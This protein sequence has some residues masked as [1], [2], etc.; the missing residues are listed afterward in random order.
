MRVL[1]IAAVVA[2]CA[3]AQR[4]SGELRLKVLDPSGLPLQ[5]V[6]TLYGPA[7]HVRVTFHTDANGTAAVRNVPFGTYRV[8]VAREGFATDSRT[9]EIQFAAPLQ[10][11]VALGVAPVNAAVVVEDVDPLIDP[12]RTGTNYFIGDADL[13]DRRAALPGRGV[14]SMIDEQPGW[15]LEANG[16]LHPRGAEYGVQYVIDGIPMT[17]NRSPSFSP[18]IE[19]EDVQAMNVMTSGYPAEF[20]RKLG[21]VIEVATTT[22][23]RDGAHG[24][25]S[26]LGQSFGTES[27]YARIQQGWK[28]SFVALSGDAARSDRYLDPPVEENF[29]NSGTTGGAGLRF[30]RDLTAGDRIRFSVQNRAVRFE[31]PNERI[32]QAAGQRQDRTSGEIGGT[33]AYTRVLSPAWVLD[34]RGTGRDESAR[35][36]SN[37]FSTP[38]LAGQDRGFREG[39]GNASLS[40]NPARNTFKAGVETSFTSISEAFHFDITAPGYFDPGI[41]AAFRFNQRAEGREQAAYIQDAIHGASWNISAGL[42]WDHYKLLVGEQAWSPRL[43]AAW[44]STRLGLIIRGSYDRAFQTPAFENILLASSPRALLLGNAAFAPIRPSRGDFIEGG[45][46]KSLFGR[47]RIDS[48]YFVRRM[49]NFPDDS[50]LLNTGVTF[51]ISFDHGTVRGTEVKIEVPR[52]GPVSGF[53]SYTNMLGRAWLPAAGGLFLGSDTALL[54]SREQIPITQ[55][56]RNTARAWLRSQLGRRAWAAAGASYGSGLPVD[57]ENL[58]IETAREQYGD[59]I[60][61][62]VN[63]QRGRLRPS[64]SL[65]FSAGI[66]VWRRDEYVLRIQGDVLNATERLNVINFAGLFSGTALAAPRTVSVRA[67][68]EF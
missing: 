53:V 18:E 43:G 21:G 29:A 8:Q 17:E 14:L 64:L 42:R 39:Y 61:S 51:P 15:F 68:F 55:D 25:F 10:L 34:A 67:G 66:D 63:L 28:K 12:L 2:V 57:A 27:G 56:Q 16:V 7:V 3:F 31:I 40:G 22:D 33:V 35:L 59:R 50:L 62:R 6:G 30:E 46:V 60:L 5:A 52:W 24:K 26:A 36:W 20:G 38:I 19:V 23:R 65:D 48:K 13:R 4:G 1:V 32:Q 37:T 49:N 45:F 9:V 47:A 44:H 54:H 58:D 11:D 41:P